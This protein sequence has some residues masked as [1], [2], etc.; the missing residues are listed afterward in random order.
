MVSF[1]THQR[2]KVQFLNELPVYFNEDFEDICDWFVDNK[3]S[4][5]FEDDKTKS[6][7]F[8]SKRKTRNINIRCKEMN[9]KKQAQVTYLGC[10]LDKSMCG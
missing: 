8:I 2:F 9:L 10:V 7:I 5:H 1:E 3:L 4:I 6:I